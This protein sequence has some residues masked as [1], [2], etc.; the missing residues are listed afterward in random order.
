MGGQSG[1]DAL[2]AKLGAA[3]NIISTQAF[4]NRGND[5]V[6][7]VAP[8]KDGKVVIQVSVTNSGSSGDVL[9]IKGN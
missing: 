9:V 3:G 8:T 2:L 6:H 5:F 1:G 7:A 4:G